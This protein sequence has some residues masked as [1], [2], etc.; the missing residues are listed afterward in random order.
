MDECRAR[1][2]GHANAVA[3]GAVRA[4]SDQQIR[5]LRDILA[6][7]LLVS[8]EAAIGD[9]YTGCVNFRLV[10]PVET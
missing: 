7:H 8:L 10:A 5:P 3:G 4:A 2:L 6:D 1:D 9:Q